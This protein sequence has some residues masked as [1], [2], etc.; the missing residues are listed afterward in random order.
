[1]QNQEYPVHKII[2]QLEANN[3]LPGILFRTARKQCD[4]DIQKLQQMPRYQISQGQKTEIVKAIDEIIV[5]YKLQRDVIEASP[6][7][8]ALVEYGVGAHHA[9]QLLA[10]RLLL[11]ELMSKGALRLLIATGTVAAGVDFPARSVVITAHSKRG[12]DGFKTLT[13]SEFQQMSGRAGRRGKDKVGF[14]LVAPSRYSD[15]RVVHDISKMPPEPLKSSYFAAP[16]TVLNLLKHRSIYEL[17]YTVE[18]SLASFIDRKDAVKLR[19]EAEKNEPII[20]KIIN[21]DQKKKAEKKSRKLLKDAEK[22]EVNQVTLLDYSLDG[23]MKLG[24]IEGT[25]LSTKGIWAAELCTSLVLEIAEGIE[26]GVINDENIY[27]LVGLI[28]SISGDTHRQY[29]SLKKPVIPQKSFNDLKKILKKVKDIYVTP[30]TQDIEVLPDAATT[31]I[32]WMES[33]DWHNFS[34]LLKLGKVAEGDVARLVTQTADSLNQISRLYKTHPNLAIAA[35]EG[36][37]M[38]LRSPLSDLWDSTKFVDVQE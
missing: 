20:Q 26:D 15:A 11:E 9:G 38:I 17:R 29:F 24:Y 18:K 23:L 25:G 30:V 7:Y 32:T 31:V 16:S 4:T 5:K 28:A 14:C 1:M 19:I 6:H 3:L 36:R 34:G 13:A 33:K 37:R 35:E 27:H 12:S 22:L 10:W 21:S 2:F 8:F